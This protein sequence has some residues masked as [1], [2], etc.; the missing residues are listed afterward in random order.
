MQEQHVRRNLLALVGNFV[1][2][3]I[4]FTFYDPVVIVPAF[5]KEFSDSS[6]YPTSN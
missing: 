5:V 1:F 2:F 3:S 6:F 4:G